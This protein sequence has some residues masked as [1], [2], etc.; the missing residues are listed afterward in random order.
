M[1]AFQAN[2]PG[3]TSCSGGPTKANAATSRSRYGLPAQICL[4]PPHIRKS[5]NS[6]PP[7]YASGD[8]RCRCAQDGAGCISREQWPPR[9]RG[10]ALCVPGPHSWKPCGSWEHASFSTLKRSLVRPAAPRS[11]N[12][13]GTS[14]VGAADDG[15]DTGMII[16]NT[17]TT[18]FT[19][20]P[21]YQMLATSNKPQACT[22]HFLDGGA[23]SYALNI[24]L[25]IQPN[26][27]PSTP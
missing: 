3:P 16:T 2:A 12:P 9:G 17:A 7:I 8:V 23:S 20:D 21:L 25:L 11:L 14:E 1:E 13:R 24:E 6:A 10:T 4:S 5:R 18:K 15:R 19:H 26:D 27:T 22:I